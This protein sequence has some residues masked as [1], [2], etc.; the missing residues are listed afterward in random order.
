MNIKVEKPGAAKMDAL[1]V[2]SW[3]TWY[4][5]ASTFPWS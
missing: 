3:P 4:K 5:E 1:G 2:F